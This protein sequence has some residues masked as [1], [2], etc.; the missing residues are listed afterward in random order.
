MFP[1]VSHGFPIF[2]I[3]TST[4]SQGFPPRHR[5]AKG[6]ALIHP[7]TARRRLNLTAV[8]DVHLAM[9]GEFQ[10]LGGKNPRKSKG[11]P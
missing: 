8:G 1:V 2:T 7:S 11:K 9:H 10:V 4:F 5:A 3:E 6:Y